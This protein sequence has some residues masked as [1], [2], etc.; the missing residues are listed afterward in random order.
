MQDHLTIVV[1]IPPK[2]THPNNR[3]F[4][5]MGARAK[6]AAAKRQREDACIAALAEMNEPG[7]PY[8]PRWKNVT[9]QATFHRQGRQAKLMDLDNSIAWLKN[10]IDG[11]ADAGVI[12]NDRGVVP[13]P[14]SQLLG[15]AAKDNMVV[16]LVKPIQG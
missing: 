1:P 8:K 7:R 13:L 14:C 9:V 16:I 10:S 4:T 15:D 3:P 12:E 5:A 6:A 11:L 2:A